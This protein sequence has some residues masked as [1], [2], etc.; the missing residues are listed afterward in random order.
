MS[1]TPST[2]EA[3][4]GSLDFKVHSEFETNLSYMRKVPLLKFLVFGVGRLKHDWFPAH[5]ILCAFHLPGK[6]APCG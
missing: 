2:W 3:E 1:V 5:L 6:P 4:A